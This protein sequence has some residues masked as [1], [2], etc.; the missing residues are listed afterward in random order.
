MWALFLHL[1]VLTNILAQ[2]AVCIS[3]SH[4]LN[5]TFNL[6][7]ATFVYNLFQNFTSLLKNN[8]PYDNKHLARDEAANS[9]NNH[10]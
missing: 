1:V 8:H 10:S 4:V 3:N 2:G 9:V 7:P 6:K 5:P